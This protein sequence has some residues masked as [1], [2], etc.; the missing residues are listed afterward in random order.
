MSVETVKLLYNDV[1]NTRFTDTQYSSFLS[2]AQSYLYNMLYNVRPDLFVKSS[3]VTITKDAGGLSIVTLPAET[4][5]IRFKGIVRGE[6]SKFPRLVDYTE[7]IAKDPTWGRRTG[8]NLTDITEYAVDTI[9][10]K[11]CLYFDTFV[12]NTSAVIQY[13]D[14]SV[15]P[16]SRAW[17]D[18]AKDK[19]ALYLAYSADSTSQQDQAIAQAYLQE[20]KAM[21]TSQAGLSVLDRSPYPMQ[22]TQNQMALLGMQGQH[23]GAK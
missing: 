4:V 5:F 18:E 20:F 22:T 2:S 16:T 21:V 19:Y 1:D 12:P 7:A 14:P 9:D 11:T 8:T 3:T 6:D 13:T 17:M 23:G 15:V 10:S